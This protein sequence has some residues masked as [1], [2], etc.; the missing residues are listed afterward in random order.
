M[1]EQFTRLLIIGFACFFGFSAYFG[2][3]SDNIVIGIICGIA[4]FLIIVISGKTMI[5][6]DNTN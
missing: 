5:K 1:K 3:I 6:S 4:G 2:S